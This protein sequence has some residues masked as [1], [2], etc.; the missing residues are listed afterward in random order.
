MLQQYLSQPFLAKILS[1]C[2][3][4]L[5]I[6]NHPLNLLLGETTL[7]LLA[8]PLVSSR[9]VHDTIGINVEGNLNLR[10]SSWCW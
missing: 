4:L 6:L 5:S 3:K 2:L 7:V 10:N 1:F 9:H 8:D